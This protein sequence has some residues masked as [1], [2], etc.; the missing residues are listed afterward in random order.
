MF[1]H[2]PNLFRSP[3]VLSAADVAWLVIDTARHRVQV[4]EG[5]R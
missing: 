2:L 5:V 1:Q 3:I 4:V